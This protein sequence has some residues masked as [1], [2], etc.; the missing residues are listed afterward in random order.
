MT[1][2]GV[3]VSENTSNATPLGEA[4]DSVGINLADFAAVGKALWW[5]VLIR[6]ILAILFGILAIVFPDAALVGLTIV[7]AAYAIVD[8]IMT[9]AHAIRIRSTRKR[10]IWLLVQ[11]IL[12]LLAGIV[13]A[14]FPAIAGTLGALVLLWIIA[15]WSLFI[16]FAGLPAAAAMTGDAGRKIWAYVASALSILF[17]ILLIVLV[18]LFPFSAVLS[19]VWVIGVYAIVFGVLLIVLAITARGGARKVVG[20][21]RTA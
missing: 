6:G 15:F 1:T 9:I 14:I 13:A 2:Q 3:A 16:G 10:W 18:T 21:A 5:L 11:G 12:T 8:G 20:G 19:L 4:A 17:G 7:F